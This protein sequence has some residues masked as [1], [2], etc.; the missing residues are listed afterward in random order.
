MMRWHGWAAARA[1]SIC[2][3]TEAATRAATARAFGPPERDEPQSH[4]LVVPPITKATNR[5]QEEAD[6]RQHPA[7][8]PEHLLLG[9]IADDETVATTVLIGMGVNL[10]QLAAT[11]V[12]EAAW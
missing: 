12:E 11:L 2:G 10:N 6:A 8:T 4:C 7:I 1:L 3:A 5:A 9:L